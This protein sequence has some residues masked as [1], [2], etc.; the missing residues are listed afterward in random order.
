MFKPFWNSEK[1][2]SLTAILISVCTLFVF[3]YQ[4]TLIRQHQYKSVYPHLLFGNSGGGTTKYAFFLANNG[5]GPA[6]IKSIEVK[7]SDGKQFEDVVDY[8]DS[9]ITAADSIQY[10]HSN[11]FPGRLI[12]QGEFIE[13]ISHDDG[14]YRTGHKLI[15]TIYG[16]GVSI[17]LIYES[18]YGEQWK[19]THE[20]PIP[21]KLD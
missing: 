9:K 2:L 18:I 11:I 21:E 1:L 15:E 20:M 12:P 8:V 7:S 3:V 19:I 4:T 14:K 13:I 17:T 5:I 16:E 10:Y 6:I